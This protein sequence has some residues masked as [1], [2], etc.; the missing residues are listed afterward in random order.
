MR[1]CQRK[2]RKYTYTELGRSV[3]KFE[4]D[5]LEIPARGVYHERFPDGDDTL[6]GARNRA[7]QHEEVVLDNTIMREATHGSDGLLRDI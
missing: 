1:T 6:L 2:R 7:L 5:L 3:D 4:L